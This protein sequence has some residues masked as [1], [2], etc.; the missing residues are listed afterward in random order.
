MYDQLAFNLQYADNA[1]CMGAIPDTGCSAFS[2]NCIMLWLLVLAA[3][4]VNSLCVYKQE[5]QGGCTN[6]RNVLSG[7]DK[8]GE[9]GLL[10]IN[11]RSKDLTSD[12]NDTVRVHTQSRSNRNKR[13]CSWLFL[14]RAS[15]LRPV[16]I[17]SC[18]LPGLGP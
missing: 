14:L 2:C 9:G 10:H 12:L 18:C 8:T 6:F 5:S 13:A 16:K 4:T 15:A 3:N 1:A 7:V 11:R 17:G